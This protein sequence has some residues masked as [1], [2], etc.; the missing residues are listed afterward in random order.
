MYK[1][2]FSWQSVLFFLQSVL[3]LFNEVERVHRNVNTKP[4][5]C[6]PKFMSTAADFYHSKCNIVYCTFCHLFKIKYLKCNMEPTTAATFRSD[7]NS[8]PLENSK[9]IPM[10][11]QLKTEQNRKII[12]FCKCHNYILDSEISFKYTSLWDLVRQTAWIFLLLVARLYLTC[13]EES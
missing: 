2:T 3:G 5:G 6:A 8:Y 13:T 1:R 10:D 11:F 12:L 9:Q 4:K 7:V